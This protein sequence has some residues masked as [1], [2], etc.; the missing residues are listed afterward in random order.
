MDILLS[1]FMVLSLYFKV[2]WEPE[3]LF[4]VVGPPFSY[5]VT[6]RFFSQKPK[7]LSLHLRC[8]HLGNLERRPGLHIKS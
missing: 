4:L 8:S 1:P 2:P 7:L 5:K 3:K 6:L